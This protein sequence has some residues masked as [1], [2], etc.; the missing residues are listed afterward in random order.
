MA[1]QQQDSSNPPLQGH[2]ALITGATGG[3]GSCISHLL[4]SLG[5][6]LALHYNSDEQTASALQTSLQSKYARQF[7]SEFKAYQADMARYDDVRHMHQDI[8]ST[9]GAPTIL[10]NNAGSTGGHSGVQSVGEVSIEAFERTWRIN[11]G[12]AYLLTQLCVPAMEEKGWGIVIFVSSVAGITGGIIGP[13]YA[14]AK[15]ALHGMV[16]WLANAYAKKGITVNGIAPALIEQTKMLP[17]SNE[18]LS[19]SMYCLLTIPIGR[20]G[21]PDEI[22]ETMLWMIKTGY[23]TNKVIAVDGGMFPQ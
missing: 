13:H 4:A 8:T 6:S 11:C 17:G 1:E 2:L 22:A 15:S 14:S 5:S 16:H 9:Q 3:I 20:L 23:V 12:S 7:G 21:T 10:I 19:K 18:E